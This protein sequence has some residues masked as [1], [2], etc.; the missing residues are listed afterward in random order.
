MR[1]SFNSFHLILIGTIGLML[2][3]TSVTG[4]VPVG[5]IG[6][7]VTDISEA[8]MPG[9]RLTIQEKQ[10]GVVRMTNT[11][12]DGRYQFANLTPG[13]YVVEVSSAGFTNQL[14]DLTL[15]VGDYPEVNFQLQPGAAREVVE[16][17]GE[18]S[19]LDTTNFGVSGS[20]GRPQIQALPLNGRNFLELARIEPGVTALSVAN[21]GSMGNNYQRVSLAGAPYLQT[22]VSVDGSAVN[23]RINGG[24]SQNF[25]QETVQEF[26]ISTF[27]FDLAT[28]ATGAGAINIVTRRGGNDHHGSLFFNYRDND[29]A[30]Y[31]ALRRNP[32]DP[33][34]QFA[35]RQSGF[36]LSGPF[37]RNRFFW[38]TNFE[39]NN[40]DGVFA[41]A[42]N[43]P[44]FSKLDHV[45]PSTLNFDLFN[46][47]LDG[48]LNN[49]HTGFLRF[50]LDKNNNVAPPAGGI[51]MP[52][53]WQVSQTKAA[54]AEAGLISV[55]TP[56]LVNDL[57]LS[58]SYLS[59]DLNAMQSDQCTARPDCI[60]LRSPQ[61][62]LFDAPMFRIGHHSS[63]PKTMLQRN[64]QVVNN[65]TYHRGKH[66]LN[67]GGQWQRLK[68]G[69][70]HRFYEQPQI[71]LWGPTD[72]QRSPQFA[73][74]YDALPASL[75]DPAASPP[76]AADILQLPLR[77]FILG[78]GDPMLPGPYHHDRASR[79]DLLRL[80]FQNGWQLRTGLN[81]SYGLAYLH[82]TRV[83]NDDLKWPDYLAPIAAPRSA[84]RVRQNLEPRI[85]LVWN[86][87]KASDTVLRAGVGLFHDE[88]NFFYS[89]LERA[90]LGPAGNGRAIIDGAVA[91]LNFASTPTSYKGQDLLSAYSGIRSNIAAKLGNGSDLAVRGIEVFKQGD[92]LFDPAGLLPYAIHMSVGLQR[93]LASNLVVNADYVVRRFLRFGSFQGVA[94]LDRNRFNRPRV[95]G[96]NANTGE[97]SFVRNPVLPLCTA[98]QT[99][100]LD[101]RDQCSTGPINVYGSDANYRYEGLHVKLE[102]RFSS[103]IQVTAS[104][105]LARNTGWVEFTEYDNFASAYGNVSDHRRHRLT[106]S[107]YF[108]LPRYSG[109]SRFLRRVAN[110]WTV[111]FISQMETAT[112]LDTMLSGVDLDGDG[113]SRTLLPGTTRHNTFEKGS[114]QAWLGELVDE[115]N[116]GIEARTRR[117]TNPDGTTTVVRPRTP[118]NQ[119][120]ALITLPDSFSN[121]DNFITQDLRLTRKIGLGDRGRLLLMGEVFNLFNV[122]N[123]SGYSNVLNQMNYG[124]PS[125][126]AAQV[127]GSGGPRAFQV[128]LRFEF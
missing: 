78:I 73:P 82:Q 89:F 59:N 126:R 79:P 116:A 16:V 118:F 38:F 70:D 64:L 56:N 27:V 47:R 13:A 3:P 14:Y 54:Q 9:V 22:R 32:D 63:V 125:A 11:R 58:Y 26:Q 57:R 97:V 104:Y 75:K 114:D 1:R 95:T 42:N 115:Y 71:T 85:G 60:G 8:V 113:I 7:T 31:P 43:H 2:Y 123:L 35:R 19:A 86:P 21:P 40:Q 72:L 17:S 65:A 111:A 48:N 20:V 80:H 98:A 110:D 83:F 44:I 119:I 91:G 109:A 4:Q 90:P 102:K 100:A 69:S 41:V 12:P 37:R 74:L 28:G 94:Q 107:G 23:D 127:F 68:L 46:L 105:A 128:A 77:S 117:T 25:S 24:T 39:H 84:G 92:R 93:Q 61:I 101:P 29:M 62:Q 49:A 34:P 88:V 6:G 33:D 99:S 30:A 55:V 50:S 108:S 51:Y 5:G 122:S 112:P 18:I 36:S 52:S 96:I 81:L 103:D 67:I 45:H 87:R 121:G 10:T 120:L 106:V 15:R 66:R 53:N 124:Q 76:T